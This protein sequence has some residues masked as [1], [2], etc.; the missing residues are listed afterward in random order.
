MN[1]SSCLTDVPHPGQFIREELDAREWS[2]RD[3][4][5]ILGIPEQAINLI[6]SGKSGISPE[7]A[8]PESI[9]LTCNKHMRCRTRER[10]TPASRGVLYY[11]PRIRF[12]K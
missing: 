4:A 3:L 1:I 8:F 2:Q 11:R 10:L 5:Y 7:M 6:I 9:S 12:G